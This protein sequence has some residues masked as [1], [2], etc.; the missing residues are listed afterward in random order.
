MEL[1]GRPADGDRLLRGTASVAVGRAVR[2]LDEA[3][4]RPQTMGHA[5]DDGTCGHSMAAERVL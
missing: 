1:N 2:A 3:T 5:L 4:V